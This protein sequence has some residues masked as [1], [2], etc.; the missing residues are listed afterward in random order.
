MK[1]GDLLRHLRRHGCNLKREGSSHSLWSNPAT[2]VVE[3]I[4]R[5]TEISDVLVKKI[6]RNLSVP[7]LGE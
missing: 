4:P 7:V 2:G 3:A 6:C 1:R 5:H